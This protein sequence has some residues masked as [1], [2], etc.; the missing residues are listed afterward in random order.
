MKKKDKVRF[1]ASAACGSLLT[2]A[3]T[4]GVAEKG[5]AVLEDE[6]VRRCGVIVITAGAKLVFAR[7]RFQ[8]KHIDQID[9]KLLK[10][11]EM[12]STIEWE[13][14]NVEFLNGIQ[15]GTAALNMLHQVRLPCPICC[16][17]VVCSL[18][19]QQMSVEDAERIMDDSA[20]AIETQN[21][22]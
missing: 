5:D 8:Q 21:V 1:L 3:C 17:S 7:H 6:K 9:G 13:T 15:S 19:L 18:W 14:Q 10:L 22:R 20:A 16:R 11:H 2:V 12:V 4:A